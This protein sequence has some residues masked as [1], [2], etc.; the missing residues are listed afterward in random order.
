MARAWVA[1]LAAGLT[2]TSGAAGAADTGTMRFAVYH[3]DT[4]IGTHELRFTRESPRALDVEIDID[5]SVDFAFINFYTYEHENRT[6][7]RDGRLARMDARTNDD[8]EAH[9]VRARRTENGKL[10]VTTKDGTERT[11]PGDAL[12]STYWMRET[13]ERGRLLN[14]QKGTFGEVRTQR[15]GTTTV[16]GPGGPIE[17]TGYKMGGDIQARAWY[18]AQGRWVSLKFTAE[19]GTVRYELTHREGYIPN[20]VPGRAGS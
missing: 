5:L 17:A 4:R 10:R 14:T 15:M 8:G 19:G 16:P 20:A 9:R 7:W 6:T 13:I 1:A 18:D 2:L 11:L 12:P 3:D